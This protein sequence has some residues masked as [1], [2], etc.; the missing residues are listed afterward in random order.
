MMIMVVYS[1]ASVLNTLKKTAEIS[2]VLICLL[3]FT[4]EKGTT[5]KEKSTFFFLSELG[6]NH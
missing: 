6:D 1:L 5:V 4:F 2:Y 3:V